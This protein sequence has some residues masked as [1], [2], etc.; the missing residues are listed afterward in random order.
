MDVVDVRLNSVSCYL[1][2]QDGWGNFHQP[3]L[4]QRIVIRT[5]SMISIV[6]RDLN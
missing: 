5:E 4:V 3:L 2:V 6:E 1:V